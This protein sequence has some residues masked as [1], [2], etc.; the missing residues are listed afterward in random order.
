MR[1]LVVT[2]WISERKE[3][4]FLSRL[5]RLILVLS[6]PREA[7]IALLAFGL[8]SCLFSIFSLCVVF[9]LQSTIILEGY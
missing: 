8:S 1:P 4:G 6:V 7:V 9:V 3:N 5:V 2:A